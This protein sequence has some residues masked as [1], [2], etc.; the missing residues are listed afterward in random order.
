MGQTTSFCQP[1]TACGV[2]KGSLI[3]QKIAEDLIALSNIAME[4]SNSTKPT[5]PRTSIAGANR[6]AL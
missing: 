6:R 4:V 3:S 5:F 1:V 2:R